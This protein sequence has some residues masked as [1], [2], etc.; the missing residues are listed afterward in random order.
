[1]SESKDVAMRD[2]VLGTQE[3]PYVRAPEDW[4]ENGVPYGAFCQCSKCGYRG[5]STVSFD[6]H[7]NKPGDKLVC[8]QCEGISNY[9]TERLMRAEA[10]VA[11]A[12]DREG[13]HREHGARDRLR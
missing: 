8:S 2:A 9:A 6:Y 13:E 1:M 10:M 4:D 7:A 3:L 5:T 11:F 12:E